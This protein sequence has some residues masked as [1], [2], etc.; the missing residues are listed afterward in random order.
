[1]LA[2]LRKFWHSLVVK[3]RLAREIHPETFRTMAAELAQLAE[4]ASKVH[5]E[6]QAFQLKARR[7]REEM[8]ELERMATLPEF[9]LLPLKK[10]KELRESLL[11]SREQLLKTLSDAPVVTTTPQ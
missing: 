8:L 2:W 9:R 5:P 6:E 1:M 4:L 11:S 10:R 3:R 7:I